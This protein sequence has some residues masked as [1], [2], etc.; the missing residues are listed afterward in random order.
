MIGKS[1]TNTSEDDIPGEDSR[2]TAMMRLVAGGDRDAFAV[3]VRK[4][5]QALLNFFYRMNVYNGDREDL[6]QETFVRLFNYRD[7]YRPTA[8]FTTFLY[9]VA[10]QVQVDYY[11]KQQRRAALVE[12]L[13]NEPHEEV[14]E[15]GGIE[16]KRIRIE[17]ALNRLSD[18]M[19][20]VVVMSI[21]QDLKYAEIA[22]ILD[23]PL[24]TVKTRMFHALQKLRKVM[25]NEE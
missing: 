10:R 4:Y 22:E 9:L 2:D 1:H 18:E 21:Y 13:K 17:K 8:R 19:R 3:L 15:C 12:T 14:P 23:I 6:V 5:Q 24:G 16:E 7:R 20:S 25:N 11:R